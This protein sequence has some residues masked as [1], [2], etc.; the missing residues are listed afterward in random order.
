MDSFRL[1]NYRTRRVVVSLALLLATIVPALMPAFAGA[2]QATGRSITLSSSSKAATGVTYTVNFT[3]VG[4]AGAFVVDFCSDSPVIGETCTPPSGFSASSAAS[5]TTGFT[6]VTGSTSQVVVAGTIG[7][8]A[9]VSVA[10]TGITNP[11]AAG[12]LYARIVTYDTK[13]HAQAYTST[14]L[15]T[16]NVDQGGVAVSITDTV[17]VSGAVLESMT[18]CAASQ[19][20]SANCGNAS[21]NLPVLK[22]G[23]TVGAT[24]A[25]D[26]THLS[27]GD[28]YTQISTNASDGAVVSLKSGVACGGLKRVEATGCDIV[29]AGTG[30]F[31]AGT[32]KFGVKAIADTTQ[33]TT[34][35]ATGATFRIYPSSGYDGSNYNL[36]WVSG[37]ATGV[38]SAYGDPILD[39]SGAP[40]NNR[41]MKLTFGASVSNNTPAGNY[42]AD[43][44][45]IA[46]GTF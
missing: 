23:E 26:S 16:G 36:N 42:A 13:A 46:T 39:T 5:T 38:A 40:T 43:L 7:A 37:N 6:D 44:S 45:L 12:P 18:F 9:S 29:P 33:D 34:V 28:I 30:G 21:S 14:N 17:G 25:L 8:S 22:L 32:A 24:V 41:N 2:A 3:A 11:S 35:S 4:A 31:S 20:I 10:L 19:P 27:T 15:G 1:F